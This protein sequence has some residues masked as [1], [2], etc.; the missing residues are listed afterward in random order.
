MGLLLDAGQG[1]SPRE[2]RFP[3]ALS[4]PRMFPV[5]N[6]RMLMA[7][8]PSQY[9]PKF[10]YLFLGRGWRGDQQVVTP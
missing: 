8:E 4:L 9:S 5:R 2:T 10:R 7:K 6:T 1:P 3:E